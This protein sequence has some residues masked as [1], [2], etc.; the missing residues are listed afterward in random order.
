MI[1][2]RFRGRNLAARVAWLAMLTV[3]MVA[4]A[5]DF[6][7]SRIPNGANFGCANCHVSQ[8]GSGP[9][10]PFGLA[11]QA[12]VGGPANIA[13][14]SP[15]LAALDSDGDG[16]ANGA[17]LGDPEGDGQATPGARVTNPG[18]ATS[19]P[20]A[21]AAPEVSV[22]APADGS[23]LTAPAVAPVEVTATDSDGTV[24]RVEFFDGERLLGVD[25]EA[26]Y[27]LLVDWALG[28]HAITAKAT[29]DAGTTTTSAS[30]TMTVNPPAAT[31]VTRLVRDGGDVDV[32]WTAGGG[33]YV[34]QSKVDLVDPWCATG[35]VT[36]GLTARVTARADRGIYRVVD[37]AGSGS[38]PLAVAL[39]G[40]FER[41]TAVET[42]GTGSGTLRLEGNTLSFSV[43]YSGLSGP[44]TLA[45]IHGP[46]SME[47]AAGVM[48]N[49]AP[50]NG[51][52][53]GTSGT[54]AGSVVVSV[55]Q[56]A[57][58]L[59]GLTYVNI[60]T[61]ANK[62]GEI[63]GQVLPVAM[64]ATLSGAQETP[65][66]VATPGRGSGHFSLEGD[67]LTF[68]ITYSGLPG[69][70]TL[71]H[72]HGPAAI[73]AGAGVMIDLAPF[74]GGA[75]GTSGRFS[76]TI[77][78]TADQLVSVASGLTY[79]NIHTDAN[80]AGEIRGQI[81]PCVTGLPLEA[82]LSG[83]AEVPAVTT[84]GTGRASLRLE[85]D[86]LSF[87]I[88]YG[89]LPGPATLAHI[90]G[91]AAAGANAGVMIN[92]APFHLGPLGVAGGFAGS[93]ALTPDQKAALTG[94]LTYVNIH[95]DA[96]KS[97]E[98]RGQVVPVGLP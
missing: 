83:D 69:A 78:L 57:L 95:T 37:L 76:G 4:S 31:R 13:F 56:K 73:G 91:A 81:L 55:E 86:V 3:P 23:T 33:P 27:S 25:L 44:A 47:A 80:K 93:V 12:I 77:A 52:A 65:V 18:N 10:N 71:A 26:P 35:G 40:A 90:H 41:P 54:L 98:I 24:A 30:V 97:G 45:H 74:H 7:V 9:R 28:A 20:P 67:Q 59:S 14:W 11:V 17:E 68:V 2:Y 64:G 89:G 42:S 79:V 53:F 75:M 19:K 22:Q 29:D 5:R 16:T 70:A 60:H 87:D 15:T 48:I 84:P 38:I 1:D 6:R 51:G 88:L 49:L 62:P 50:F 94:G 34:V 72:I 96:N 82:T 43:Q 61:D 85:G 39:G 46:A 63:R 36:T 92:L 21:N 66:P 58:I 32:D 8:F